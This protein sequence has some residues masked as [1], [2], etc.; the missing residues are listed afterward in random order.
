MTTIAELRA[1]S[2]SSADAAEGLVAEVGEPGRLVAEKLF[3][4]GDAAQLVADLQHLQRLVSGAHGIEP[5]AEAVFERHR[6]DGTR[7]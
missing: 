6:R 2:R 1:S 7:L 4:G 3:E 5:L